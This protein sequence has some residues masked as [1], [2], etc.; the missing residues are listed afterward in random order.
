ML[1]FD[2][3]L[4]HTFPKHPYH[5]T[6]FLIHKQITKLTRSLLSPAIESP[7]SQPRNAILGQTI[8]SII[9]VSI[10]KLFLL[11][12]AT[13]SHA[14]PP[15]YAY[16]AGALAVAFSS[17][18]MSLTGTI[19]P[20]AGATAL[21]AATEPAIVG[22]GWL[23]IGIVVLA[24]VLM[25]AVAALVNNVMRRWPMYWWAPMQ[26]TPAKSDD[27]RAKVEEKDGR[28]HG[29]EEANV[30]GRSSS[31]ASTSNGEEEDEGMRLI[32]SAKNGVVLP[33]GLHLSGEEW[34]MLRILEE[35]MV[36]I[37]GDGKDTSSQNGHPASDAGQGDHHAA[38]DTRS[39]NRE[40]MERGSMGDAG[41]NRLDR[42]ATFGSVSTLRD[43]SIG[44][45]SGEQREVGRG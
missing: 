39:E 26:A 14:Q 7:F 31:S 5:A 24:T 41:D 11:Q 21:L 17:A 8:A 9:G 6:A 44:R 16:L 29:D 18:L 40:D 36:E 3:N 27:E 45:Y 34:R 25:L 23:Y 13:L 30:E 43:Q 4:Y 2:Q 38:I 32:V 12:P 19:Y 1:A 15:P 42:V 33:K 28:V 20:P 22:L 37:Y 10:T 35:R